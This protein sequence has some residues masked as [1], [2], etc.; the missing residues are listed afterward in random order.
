MH[1][2]SIALAISL[3]ASAIFTSLWIDRSTSLSC[4]TRSCE[5]KIINTAAP[6]PHSLRN[7]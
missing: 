2:L 4:I 6:Q 7:E 3:L 1:S 5:M